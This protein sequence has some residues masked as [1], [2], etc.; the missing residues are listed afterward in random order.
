MPQV[1]VALREIK[2]GKSVRVND[3]M[4]YVVTMG[5]EETKSL[6]APKRSYTPQDV[7]KPDSG[8][9]PDIDYYLYKQIFPPIERLCAPIPGTDSVRLAECLGL[10]V[11]K[12]SIN[13]TGSTNQQSKEIFPLESQIP[14]SI[15]FQDA[16]RFTMRCR[17]CKETTTFEGLCDSADYCSPEGI[18]CSNSDCKQVFSWMSIVMQL[19]SQLRAQTSAYY[20]GWLVCDDTSCGNR[21]RQMSVY[22]HRCLGPNGRAEGCLGR[23]AYEY[24]EKK[25]Y[26]QLL[27]FAGLFDTDKAKT[28]A[29]AEK[30]YAEKKDRIVV[31]A[32]TNK[33][34][35]EGVKS[36]IDGY[37]KKCG[38]QWVEMDTLFGFALK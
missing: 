3:V 31:L 12:Y 29:K 6:P 16:A 17:H 30:E 36:V 8:L 13:T 1:Q 23:M 19:E 25:L 15:R 7:Q 32:E 9:V 20:E 5:D 28:K 38:R 10:D 33:D 24:P 37:L 14:D 4:S 35:F 26:N 34:A 2:R 27:Y 21:T 18:M 11:R 22:G